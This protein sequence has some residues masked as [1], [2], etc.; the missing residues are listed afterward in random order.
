MLFVSLKNK[1]KNRFTEA[2]LTYDEPGMFQAVKSDH[3]R[4]ISVP[5]KTW[6]PSRK[7]A[8]SPPP[9]SLLSPPLN[10]PALSGSQATPDSSQSL[11]ICLHFLAFYISGTKQQVPAFP[12]R[13]V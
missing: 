3:F 6:P 4:Y 1:Q 11:R 12:P 10:L 7:E 9:K 5:V 13:S 2:R 8:R